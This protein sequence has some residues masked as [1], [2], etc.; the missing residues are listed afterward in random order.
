MSIAK[1][2]WEKIKAIQHKVPPRTQTPRFNNKM[3]PITIHLSI[4]TLNINEL[5]SSMKRHRPTE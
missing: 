2:L 1:S 4:I 5:T 3:T